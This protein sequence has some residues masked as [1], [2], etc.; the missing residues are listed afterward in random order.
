MPSNLELDDDLICEAMKW[1]NHKTKRAAVTAALENY[2]RVKNRAAGK[3]SGAILNRRPPALSRIKS[4]P[5]KT[6][7]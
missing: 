6:A 3:N 7:R 5:T 2:I 1:G 4:R